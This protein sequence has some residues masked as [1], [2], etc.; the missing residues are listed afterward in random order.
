MS[1]SAVGSGCGQLTVE[2]RRGVSGVSLDLVT[3]VGGSLV[4]TSA[5]GS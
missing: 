3:R 5:F 4:L 2:G 1:H